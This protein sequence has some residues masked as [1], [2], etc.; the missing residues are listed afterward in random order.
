MALA[1]E[2]PRD[3]NVLQRMGGL[4]EKSVVALSRNLLSPKRINSFGWY[5]GVSPHQ[6]KTFPF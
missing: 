6:N 3:E 2:S 4:G 5:I 1:D